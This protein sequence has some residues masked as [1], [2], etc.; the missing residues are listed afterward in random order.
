MP[1]RTISERNMDRIK[2]ASPLPEFAN[3]NRLEQL[4]GIDFETLELR[5]NLQ[6]KS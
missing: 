6:H 1:P 2:T 3:Q 5:G 4:T